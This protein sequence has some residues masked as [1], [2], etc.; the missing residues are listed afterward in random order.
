MSFLKQ[1]ITTFM[2]YINLLKQ[3]VG[4][5]NHSDKITKILDMGE[6][7]GATNSQVLIMI[8]KTYIP[9]GVNPEDLSVNPPDTSFIFNSKMRL[10]SFEIKLQQLID[11]LAQV[12]K[13]PDYDDCV[14]CGGWGNVECECCG[15]ESKCKE[16]NG[17]G[18]GDPIPGQ[19][20]YDNQYYV[21]IDMSYFMVINIDALVHVLTNLDVKPE[22]TIKLV[23]SEPL[24]PHIFEI[25]DIKFVTTVANIDYMEKEF[26]VKIS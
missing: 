17:S 20:S 7:Y 3:Y 26:V 24:K 6:Y 16:C 14:Q 5:S 15:N 8:P 13:I 12:P 18:N 19:F 2:K 10:N 1:T 4:H 9:E 22:D 25:G 11:T 21:Q 23:A